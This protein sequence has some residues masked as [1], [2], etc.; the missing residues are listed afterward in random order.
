MICYYVVAVV[1]VVVAD[2]SDYID[3]GVMI[4]TLSATQ[5]A[6]TITFPLIDDDVF[7]IT[8]LLSASLSFGVEEPARVTISPD[9]AQIS[10]LDD[11]SKL[12]SGFAAF[13]FILAIPFLPFLRL[14]FW[15]S[16]LHS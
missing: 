11:D 15:N 3:I 10:I 9:S 1:V 13:S 8:E 6:V 12:E 2:G 16:L 7:E 5:N 4:V 14:R